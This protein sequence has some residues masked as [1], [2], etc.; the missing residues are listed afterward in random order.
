MIA[1]VSLSG[2]KP[3]SRSA[4]AIDTPSRSTSRSRSARVS[5]PAAARE[6]T[7]P[8]PKRGSSP[9]QAM[10]SMLRRGEKPAARSDSTASIA[11]STPSTP[12]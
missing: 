1:S 2:S 11:P 6:P 10:T 4:E 12:S 9:A 8:V 5:S 7:Q 3:A